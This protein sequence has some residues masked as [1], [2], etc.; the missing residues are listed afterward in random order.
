MEDIN[1][2]LYLHKYRN[3]QERNVWGKT[4]TPPAG[5]RC[6]LTCAKPQP[7]ANIWAGST[8]LISEQ[9]CLFIHSSE[10]KCFRPPSAK[11]P[12]HYCENSHITVNIQLRFENFT[13]HPDKGKYIKPFWSWHIKCVIKCRFRRHS[14][15]VSA[16][17]VCPDGEALN[18][19]ALFGFSIFR[20][21]HINIYSLFWHFIN[22]PFLAL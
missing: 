4:T 17:P 20:L 18:I 2:W 21:H 15:I 9:L 19:L 6:N 11:W 8:P 22:F 10:L 1:A 3:V 7:Y 13:T 5:Y 14:V 12:L 16:A